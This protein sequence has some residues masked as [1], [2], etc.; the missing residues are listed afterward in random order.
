MASKAESFI[1]ALRDGRPLFG[2]NCAIP[3]AHMSEVLA[4]A[5]FDFLVIDAEHPPTGPA[6]VH[7]QL[8]ALAPTPGATFVKLPALDAAVIRQYLDL[9]VDGLMAPDLDTPEDAANLVRMTRYPPRGTRGLAAAVRAT[10][11]TRDRTYMAEAERRF[12]LIGLIE[13]RKGMENL[14]AIAAT[15]GLDILFFG[16]SDLAAQLGHPGHASHP[17]VR[18]ALDDGVAR[19]RKAGKMV[20]IVSSEADVERYRTLGAG[21]FVVGSDVTLVAQAADGLAERLRGRHS[22]TGSLT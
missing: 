22:A 4:P 17:D 10:R 19:V 5:A 2:L 9:G 6:I 8:M 15:D 7:T 16:P 11:F 1:A 12:C 3:S 20:G 13:S 14:D 18:A 21:M